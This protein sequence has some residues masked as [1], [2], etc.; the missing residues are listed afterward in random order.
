MYFRVNEVSHL[1]FMVRK[2]LPLKGSRTA[3]HAN[4]LVGSVVF[5]AQLR[6]SIAGFYGK[7]LEVLTSFP[8]FPQ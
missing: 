6:A 5:V 7:A 2:A 8:Q 1:Q 4:C 3:Q